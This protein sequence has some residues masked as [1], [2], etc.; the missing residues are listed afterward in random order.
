M[1]ARDPDSDDTLAYSLRSVEEHH[2]AAVNASLRFK[3]LSSA[4]TD[5]LEKILQMETDQNFSSQD[6]FVID[7]DTGDISFIK[8]K[9]VYI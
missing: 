6:F 2:L 7:E 5:T 1:K 3:N 8:V 4:S 9:I